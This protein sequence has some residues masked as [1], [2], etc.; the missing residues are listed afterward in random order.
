MASPYLKDFE[1][2]DVD[3]LAIARQARQQ[4]LSTGQAYMSDG[5][6]LSRADLPAINATIAELE[7][8]VAAA[9]PRNQTNLAKR[10]R[11]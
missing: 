3:S 8:R 1:A 6:Q 4:I 10:V 2:T 9:A 11:G 5:K 7:T